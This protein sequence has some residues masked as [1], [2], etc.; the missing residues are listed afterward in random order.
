LEDD[1]NLLNKV[2][3]QDVTAL[4]PGSGTYSISLPGVEP[5]S[6]IAYAASDSPHYPGCCGGQGIA[7]LVIYD[8]GPQVITRPRQHCCV[9]V[10]G[11]VT[12]TETREII[13]WHGAKL[14][15]CD[16]CQP[17]TIGG[18]NEYSITWDT[19]YTWKP[20]IATAVGDAQSQYADF[21]FMNGVPLPPFPSYFN[22]YVGNLMHVKTEFLPA[23]SA[24]C[25]CGPGRSNTV[26]AF[27]PDDCLCWFLFVWSGVQKCVTPVIS[28]SQS[29]TSPPTP[30]MPL[31]NPNPPVC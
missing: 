7:L 16:G 21:F 23:H 19:K 2:W 18:S 3:W 22:P 9:P 10:S 28:S 14:L 6:A 4:V 15:K 5:S 26:T 8:T 25:N 12:E 29:F 20:K 27:T 13:I 17:A 31:W 24:I 30:P 11:T 1:N